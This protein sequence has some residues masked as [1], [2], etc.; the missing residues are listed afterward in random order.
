MD[1][2]TLQDLEKILLYYKEDL[3]YIDFMGIVDNPKG[4]KQ[5]LEIEGLTFDC[6]YIDQKVGC[7]G[8]DYYGNIYIPIG[9][10]FMKFSYSC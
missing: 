4:Q 9:D 7:C 3:T 5:S 2:K 8:D 1:I 10:K 6:E